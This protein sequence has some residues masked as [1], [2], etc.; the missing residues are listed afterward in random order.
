VSLHIVTKDVTG[1][2]V[3]GEWFDV[4]PGSFRIDAYE[5]ADVSAEEFTEAED[6]PALYSGNGQGF[7]FVLRKSGEVFAGPL[8]SIVAVQRR[9]GRSDPGRVIAAAGDHAAR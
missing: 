9:G 6:E 5:F 7:G 2:L 3:A 8:A 4:E 1:V